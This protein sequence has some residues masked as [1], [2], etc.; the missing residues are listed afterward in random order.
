MSLTMKRGLF[1]LFHYHRETLME[2]SA[3]ELPHGDVRE[4]WVLDQ[5]NTLCQSLWHSD[6]QG[7]ILVEL[8]HLQTL[9]TNSDWNYKLQ[10]FNKL[11]LG[12]DSAGS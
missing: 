8:P 4:Q 2:L 10:A 1:Y 7:C 3:F 5:R 9:I 11:E 12:Y 6:Q